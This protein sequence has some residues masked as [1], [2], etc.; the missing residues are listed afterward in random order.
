MAANRRDT[1]SRGKNDYGKDGVT[2]PDESLAHPQI[3]Q[4]DTAGQEQ[5][6]IT[7]LSAHE[8][9]SLYP[10]AKLT[11]QES[12]P[13]ENAVKTRK[14]GYRTLPG[15]LLPGKTL[16]DGAQGTVVTTGRQE[17]AQNAADLTP[18]WKTLAYTDSP[19]DANRK[20]RTTVTMPDSAFP[21][22][23]EYSQDPET[24]ALITATYQVVQASAVSAPAIVLGQTTDYKK[25]DKWRSLKIVTVYSKPAD[26]DEQ[27]FD[28]HN[29]P[30]LFNYTDY[31]WSDACGAFS[32]IR[33]GFS[34]MVAARVAIHYHDSKETITGLT[35]I[36][37]TLQLGK[38]VQIH[39]GVLVDAGSFT[40]AGGCTGTVSFDAS[41]PDYST[42]VGSI[43]NTEQLITGE[44]VK[45]R[46]GGYYRSTRLYVYMK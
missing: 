36:P 22:L 11:H 37:K 23:T 27:K 10:T 30:S 40:Y 20:E 32:K 8:N 24:Q 7:Y 26:Y 33:D 12:G 13:G 1:R 38:G 19:L 42:Y 4:T 43:K 29:F 2:F 21:I 46:L 44:S 34:A 25:I 5:V 18:D 41:D 6:E 17:L 15:P 16:S 14:R 31:A 28:A 35:L 45:S 3:V 9:A 39:Q